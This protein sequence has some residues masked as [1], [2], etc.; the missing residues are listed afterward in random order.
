MSLISS[1]VLFLNVIYFCFVQSEKEFACIFYT[2]FLLSIC[3]WLGYKRM[4]EEK[5][6]N[7][8]LMLINFI[9]ETYRKKSF[10]R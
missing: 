8:F 10:F 6:I 7:T 1:L 2:L 3:E 5:I 9:D 4:K